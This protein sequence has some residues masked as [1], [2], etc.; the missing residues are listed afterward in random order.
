MPKLSTKE[1]K[2]GKDQIFHK[3]C[4]KEIINFDN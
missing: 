1:V 4:D 2:N 3:S